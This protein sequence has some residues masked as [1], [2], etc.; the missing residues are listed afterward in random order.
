[1]VSFKQLSESPVVNSNIV[2]I[3]SLSDYFFL[4]ARKIN[5]EHGVEE[6]NL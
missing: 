1:M 4:L 2:Y 5:Q 3:N 6:I